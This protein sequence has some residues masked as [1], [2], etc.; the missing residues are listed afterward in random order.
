M[1]VP[2]RVVRATAIATV[3]VIAFLLAATSS[4]LAAPSD[5]TLSLSALKTKL[6]TSGTV[7][8]YLKTVVKGSTIT[9]IHVT[10]LG[11][12][13]S[14]RPSSALILFQ[15]DGGV[16]TTY[17][18]IV[19]GMSG[20]P[21]YVN[22]GGT[23]KVI[24]ALSYGDTF[25]L[26]GT[27][28]A[29]PIE[30]MVDIKQ[31]YAPAG[32]QE[33]DHPVI[34]RDGVIN[35]IQIV[36]PG[37]ALPGAAADGVAVASP[38][39]TPAFI[40]GVSP[41]SRMFKRFAE[42]AAKHNINVID[43]SR[44]G[45]QSPNV[46][47]SSFTTSFTPGASIAALWSRGDFAYGGI[48]TVTYT[49]SSTVIAYGHPQDL[50]GTTDLYM[51]NAWIDGIWP[52]SYWPYKVGRIGALRGT[53]TQDRNAGI[54]GVT[55]QF[56]GETTI[57]AHATNADTCET[58]TSVVY[59]PRSLLDTA[60]TGMDGWWIGEELPPYAVYQ[61]GTYLF[62]QYS[63]PGSAQTTT[64]VVV[65]DVDHDQQYTITMP[66]F[67]SDSTDIL[68]AIVWDA[69]TAVTSLM[70]ELPDNVYHYEILSVDLT[71]CIST[72]QKSA[73]IVG[74]DVPEVLH[75]GDNLVEV[76]YLAY[77]IEATQTVDTTLTI[78]AGVSPRGAIIAAGS[79]AGLDQ[80][81]TDQTTDP[82]YPSRQTVAQIVSDLNSTLPGNYFTLRYIPTTSSN[83]A[84]M[85]EWGYGP[86]YRLASASTVATSV[87]TTTPTEW[88][89]GGQAIVYPTLLS[90]RLAMS[91]MDYK[92]FNLLRGYVVDSADDPGVLSLYGTPAGSSTESL[93]ATTTADPDEGSFQF[94]IYGLSVNTLLRVH[95]DAVDDYM[96]SDTT[97]T[98]QVHASVRLTTSASSVRA[99]SS[100][101][102]T[103]SVTPHANV[104]AKVTFERYSHGVWRKIA[105]KTLSGSSTAKASVS[106]RVPKGSTK[107]RAH[108]LGSTY[109]AATASSTK[110]VR[111]R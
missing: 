89:M 7:D 73:T 50:A 33:L 45:G 24:G 65:R 53:I 84:D 10:V 35:R 19:A 5:E 92:G 59:V 42:R 49:D 41:N 103:A 62:D 68:S 36:A 15:A 8:G 95:T 46:G 13:G 22:D 61:A 54:M 110:T 64:T 51:S 108:F 99:G 12:T 40:S 86:G 107:V 57:T 28:E 9:T 11:I 71:S 79:D 69:G 31:K 109:N 111:G 83:Y 78:P 75:T 27:G 21:I 60:S 39:A 87:V 96:A 52:S 104:G 47:D 2:I 102:L 55:D 76:S 88:A 43:L 98:A 81:P 3:L 44:A 80:F 18:G 16:I 17:G 82:S 101:R 85:S 25:T 66:N 91:V 14:D 26:G 34:T 38:L 58:T 74:L 77:G 63:V 93:L 90:A 94:P 4:A 105:T 106:W 100:V 70:Q 48:G 37:Q 6:D 72:H 1:H 32:M 97:M 30:A 29:T 20:S 23:D 56:T 67:V